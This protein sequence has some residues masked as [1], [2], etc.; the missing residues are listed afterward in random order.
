MQQL[1]IIK[2][3]P[4]LSKRAFWDIE[5]SALDFDQHSKFIITRVFERGNEEDMQVIMTCYSNELIRNCLK[6]APQLLPIASE[7][8]KKFFG[9]RDEDFRCNTSKDSRDLPN[10]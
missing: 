9:L 3:K 10:Y 7:R 5:L 1:L 8:A 2:D 4:T 6:D